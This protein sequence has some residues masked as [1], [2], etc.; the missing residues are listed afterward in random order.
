MPTLTPQSPYQ[1]LGVRAVINARGCATL[2]GGTLM[3][4][5]VLETFSAAA[6]SFVMIGELQ[7]RAGSVIASLTGAEDGYVVSGAAAGLTLATAACIAGLDPDIMD[8]LPDVE[9]VAAEVVMQ[10]VHRNPYDHAVRAA[11][12]RLVPVAADAEALSAAIGPKTVAAFFH[13][14]EERAG[15]SSAEFIATAHRHGIPVVVDASM[16]LPPAS[17]LRRFIEEGADLVAFSGGKAIRGP[18]GAG[19]LAGRA[20][21]LVSVALQHQDMDVL[22]ATWRARALLADGMLPRPPQHG[23][24]RAMKVSKE[25]IAALVHALERYVRRDHAAEAARWSA[26]AGDLVTQ[27]ATIDGVEAHFESGSEAS[28]PVPFAVVTLAGDGPDATAVVRALMD[29]DP[30]VLVNDYSIA[31]GIIRL[32]PE[33]VE[34]EQIPEI[35]KAF[36]RAIAAGQNNGR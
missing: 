20:D 16:S 22:P 19:F 28:R 7:E 9:G 36:R 5:E 29:D 23:I 24:G 34:S 32:N 26:V 1:R 11:G 2:A 6:T 33:N 3:D 13:A 31:E 15:L 35:V 25:E 30:R 18:Q 10:Q 14:Q 27:L 12:A 21:L 4:P 8:R 17:N